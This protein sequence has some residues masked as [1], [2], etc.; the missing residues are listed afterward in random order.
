MGHSLPYDALH[1]APDR[2][3]VSVGDSVCTY[4][5][6]RQTPAQWGEHADST[7]GTRATQNGGGAPTTA[8]R[9]ELYAYSSYPRRRRCA[10]LRTLGTCGPAGSRKPEISHC[11]YGGRD[12]TALCQAPEA[13]LQPSRIFRS[14]LAS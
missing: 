1:P 11:F 5:G 4:R 13:A 2:G 7:S 9:P 10:S 12:N 3:G 8:Q 14:Y 6:H